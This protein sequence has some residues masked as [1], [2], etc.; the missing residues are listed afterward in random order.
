MRNRS[1]SER[2]WIQT[3]T[4]NVWNK[5]KSYFNCDYI[6]FRT[7]EVSIRNREKFFLDDRMASYEEVEK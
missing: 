5:F 6:N 1:E 2:I 4:K 3:Y 7:G